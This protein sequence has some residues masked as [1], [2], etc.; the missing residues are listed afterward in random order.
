MRFLDGCVD[1]MIAACKLVFRSTPQFRVK[2]DRQVAVDS[3]ECGRALVIEY[4][5]G[6]SKQHRFAA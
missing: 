5:V 4:D 6:V 3:P 1:I 2:R